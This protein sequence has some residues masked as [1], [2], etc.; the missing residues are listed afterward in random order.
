MAVNTLQIDM[1]AESFPDRPEISLAS[2][3][4]YNGRQIVEL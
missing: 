2:I 1:G 4:E 3:R